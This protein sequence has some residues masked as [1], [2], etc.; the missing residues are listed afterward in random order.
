MVE[1]KAAKEMSAEE[2]PAKKEATET[3]CRYAT[4]YALANGRK[5]WNIC[6]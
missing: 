1:T 4:E 2:V 5:P 3:Y 6:Y